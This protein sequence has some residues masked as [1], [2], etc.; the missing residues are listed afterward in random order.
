M[1][2]RSRKVMHEQLNKHA[3]IQKKNLLARLN[4]NNHLKNSEPAS[5]N[6]MALQV[7]AT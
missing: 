1:N 3:R 6:D 5:S 7:T 4:P 2:L